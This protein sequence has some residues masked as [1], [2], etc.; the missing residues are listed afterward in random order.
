MTLDPVAG[1]FNEVADAYD[2]VIPFF[3]SFAAGFD[4]RML[5]PGPA[6]R[7]PCWTWGRVV[8]P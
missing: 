5:W 1:H 4:Q 2:E 3:S 7:Q 8:E 6:R